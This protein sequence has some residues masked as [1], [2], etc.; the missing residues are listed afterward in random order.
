MDSSE[1]H[2]RL[3]ALYHRLRD[4]PEGARCEHGVHLKPDAYVA[5]L[6]LRKLTENELLPALAQ[7]AKRGWPLG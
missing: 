2:E 3:D 6:E 1:L 7:N 5:F 4:F